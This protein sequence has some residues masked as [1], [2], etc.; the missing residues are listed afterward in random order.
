M[1]LT[2]CLA[3]CVTVCMLLST[4]CTTTRYRNAADKE[5]YAIID[6]KTPAVPN[7]DPNFTIEQTATDP[8]ADLPRS[9]PEDR[10]F[11]GS[12]AALE[13]DA[14]VIGLEEALAISVNFN[15][16]YQNQKENVFLQALALSLERHRFDFIFSGTL[17]GE[18]AGTT[19]D[20]PVPSPYLSAGD[21]VRDFGALTGTAADLVDQYAQI[22][23]SAVD[24]SG[25]GDP[26]VDIERIR[27]TTGV[28]QF[29]VDK[30]LKTGGRVAVSITSNFFRF[31]TGD[32]SV[33]TTSALVG[34]IVQP[35]WRGAG[36]KVVL[37]NLTQAERNMLYALRDFARF[38]K[39]F[40]VDVASSYFN[41]LQA[42]DQVRNNWRGYQSFEQSLERG[43][44]EAAEGRK[45]PAELG[46]LEQAALSA[47]SS[48]INSLANYSS[49]LD[50]FKILLGIPTDT[51]IVLDPDELDNLVIEHPDITADD[52]VKVAMVTRLDLYTLRDEVDDAERKLVVA[53]N[54]LRPDVDFI[55]TYRVQSPPDGDFT[56]LDFRR[57]NWSVGLD[58]GLPFD[59]KAERN[60]YRTALITE[61]RA[62]RGLS[63]AE[64]SVA[65]D[66]RD[67]WRDL[68][69]AKLNYEINL[70]EVELNARRVEEQDLRAELGLADAIDQVD[71][72]N[73]LIRAQNSLTSALVN[74]TITRLVF[75]R[76]MGILYIKPD[77]QWE[78]L[79]E[80][81][82]P[83]IRLDRVTPE[84]PTPEAPVAP[85]A[86]A[87]DDTALMVG[88]A[89]GG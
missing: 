15:R 65:L 76:D 22:V 8:L 1:K 24:L 68:E 80:E 81:T 71:A 19:T 69:Q 31:L 5:A 84:A 67:A 47:E 2:A 11:L 16:T 41:V 62:R 75:W 6:S 74:H 10:T 21:F 17:S 27:S 3:G 86:T 20:I 14:F 36:S 58:V 73:D 83:T 54:N 89:A 53:A 7:M 42:R 64:D 56:E 61:D 70:R 4:G 12:N 44:A 51:K 57:E 13:E 9:Q 78:D 55:A 29:G 43:R 33:D 63:L 77:G 59:R 34:S 72:L 50:R 18:I 82:M 39:E 52:A 79:P 66:V 49:A 37:E 48:W 30:L 46:R 88:T 40:A 85:E 87:S 45:T 38:R 60:A 25:L 23:E 35:L 28:T 32:P 26:S